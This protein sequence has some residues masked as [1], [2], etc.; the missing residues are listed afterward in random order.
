MI[1]VG[2]ILLGFVFAGMVIWL[3]KNFLDFICLAS[4][5]FPF[6]ADEFTTMAVRIR[7][8]ENLTHPHRRHLYQLLTNEKGISHWKISVGY[9]LAQLLIGISVLLAKQF[10]GIMV[11]LLLMGC[12]GGFVVVSFA[13]RRK[14]TTSA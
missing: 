14:L 3:S 11:L 1:S 4:F 7:D 2:S 9:G 5:L 8:G 6:Y 12:F 13:I 10:G